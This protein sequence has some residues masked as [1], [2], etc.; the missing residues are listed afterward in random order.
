MASPEITRKL[1]T[2][3]LG[4]LGKHRSDRQVLSV[5]C[6][7]SHHVATVYDTDA[8]LVFRSVTGPHAHGS[9][10]FVDT[11]HHG[12]RGGA[13]YVDLLEAGPLVADELPAWC[14]CGSH[15]L[16]RSELAGLV[17]KRQRTLRL[18]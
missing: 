12:D 6:A 3:A 16:S 17:A 11:A 9:R 10:D 4:A 7:R 1:A 8:G 13:E 15:M 2:E 14:D 5:Q 18:S